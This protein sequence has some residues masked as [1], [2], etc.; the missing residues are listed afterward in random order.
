LPYGFFGTD[1]VYASD[2]A[3]SQLW[4]HTKSGFDIELIGAPGDFI[5]SADGDGVRFVWSHAYSVD[6]N[7]PSTYSKCDL[8]T[9]DY[10]SGSKEVTPFRLGSSAAC[11]ANGGAGVL[12][13]HGASASYQAGESLAVYDLS[14]GSYRVAPEP[15]ASASDETGYIALLWGDPQTLVATVEKNYAPSVAIIDMSK[16]PLMP[17]EP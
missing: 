5:A 2:N 17:P 9:S 6:P 15:Y 10:P 7:A 12:K 8:W 14:D 16:Q 11:V 4:A 3:P 1:F 13:L